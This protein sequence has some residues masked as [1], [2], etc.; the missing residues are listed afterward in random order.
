MDRSDKRRTH[1]DPDGF[2]TYADRDEWE[3]CVERIVPVS[4]EQAWEAWYPAIW[5]DQDGTVMLDS[6][7]GRGRLGS[8]RWIPRIR[9]TER[10]VSV[11]LPAPANRPDVVPSI[12]Y[13]VQHFSAASYLGYV[14]F[15]PTDRDPRVT[16]IIW[17]VKWKPSVTGRLLFLG[18]H[19]LVR[20]LTTAMQQG[21]NRLEREATGSETSP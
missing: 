18:G 2:R 15:V 17:C 8:V 7:T 3:I 6:G 14:R 20:M 5:E 21:L 1:S 9:M 16:R 19:V 4:P 10:I 11:G 13:T 12:S